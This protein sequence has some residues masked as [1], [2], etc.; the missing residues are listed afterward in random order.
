MVELNLAANSCREIVRGKQIADVR[1]APDLGTVYF[2]RNGQP[3]T[4]QRPA[5]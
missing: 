2:T 5:Q 1:Y 3:G 4:W